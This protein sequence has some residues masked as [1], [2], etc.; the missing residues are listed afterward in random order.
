M[1]QPYGKDIKVHKALI[2]EL[3]E[4]PP[5]CNTH[6]INDI[7][8]F[9]NKL[10][11]VVRTLVTMKRL[12]SAQSLVYTLMDKLGPVREVLV[13]KD[14]DWEEW[15]LEEVVENLRKYVERNQVRDTED[16]GRKDDISRNRPWKRKTERRCFLETTG[17]QGQARN[18]VACIAALTS[19]SATTAQRYLI[20]LRDGRLCTEM[21]CA[22][23]T[24]PGHG[25]S[26]RVQ[27]KRMQKLRR[28][29]PL[30]NLRQNEVDNRRISGFDSREEHERAHGPRQHTSSNSTGKSGAGNGSCD[31]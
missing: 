14:D 30:V 7:H 29:T 8:H 19:I 10:S 3:E 23:S 2:K 27:I 31:V 18:P 5:I 13:Q 11:T 21:A 16:T 28:K 15:G 9:Y 22:T 17:G 24:G 1:E 25:A 20:L 12:T 4:L 26:R 6:R